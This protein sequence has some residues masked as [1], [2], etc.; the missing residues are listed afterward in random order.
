M[1]F[2]NHL[3]PDIVRRVTL[4]ITLLLTLVTLV[5]SDVFAE[6]PEAGGEESHD[7]TRPE[8]WY[9]MTVVSGRSGFRVSHYWSHGARLRAQTML[10]VNP[11]TTIV[12]GDRYWVYDVLLGEG[13]EIK[14]SEAAI[15]QDEDRG[16]PFGNDLAKMLRGGGER[17]GTESVSGLDAEVWRLTNTSGRRTI[18]ATTGSPRV[19]LRVENFNRESGESA[20]LSYSNWA[21]GFDI[22][23]DFFL[24][25]ANITLRRLEYDEFVSESLKGTVGPVLILFSDLL[26]GS[27][28]TPSR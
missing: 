16:R 26:H 1:R 2:Q 5:S 10:G 28:I 24:P 22:P 12:S 21:S 4:L 11:I 6:G 9:A 27:R 17:V 3:N 20:T 14:R 19:P 8:T 7:P 13:T 18:W 23:E 15:Q 25:P